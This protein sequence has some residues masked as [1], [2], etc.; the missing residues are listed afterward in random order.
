MRTGML[1]NNIALAFEAACMAELQAI[2]PGNVHAFA[3][4]HGMVL[5][6]FVTSAKVAAEVIALPDL[7]VGRRISK[8]IVATWAAVDCNTNLGILLLAAP[9]IEA[10]LKQKTL[11]DVLADLTQDDAAEAFA[12]INQANPAG[13]GDS[14]R[15]DVKNSLQCTLLQAMQEAATRDKIAYQYA[16]NY[17]DVLEFG[18]PLYR[19]ALSR[20][21]NAAWATTALYLGFLAQ[22]PD[23]H[24][25]RKYGLNAAEEV[26]SQAET[27]RA[28]LLGRD[29]PKTYLG[30]LLRFDKELKSQKIN[31]GTSADLTVATLLAAALKKL[32]N[33]DHIV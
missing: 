20:W 9:L 30:E 24:I 11:S 18:L 14:A 12:A 17:V 13:L 10:A 4:G 7:S 15:Y 6:D 32:D 2:K 21:Q 29:N 8:A 27:H 25:V 5:A 33:C 3:D 16:N 1:V 26:Q 19:Q 22:F 28:A 23:S 31:P